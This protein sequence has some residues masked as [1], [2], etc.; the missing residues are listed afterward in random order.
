[1]K[2]GLPIV[3]VLLL[4]ACSVLFFPAQAYC[5]SSD[6]S[7]NK[8]I[9]YFIPKHTLVLK[10]TVKVK[11]TRS[12]N[13]TSE[14][15]EHYKIS[16][17][18]GTIDIQ[19]AGDTQKACK[20][21]MPASILKSKDLSVE[22]TP[23]GL[24]AS[25]N[26]S[27]KGHASSVL[28][29]L[30]KFTASVAGTFVGASIGTGPGLGAK[31]L[32]PNLKQLPKLKQL[33]PNLFL[34]LPD[35]K[36]NLN[37]DPDTRCTFKPNKL[38]G[39]A[40]NIYNEFDVTKQ[41]YISKICSAQRALKKIGK[42]M[43]RIDQLY[44]KIDTNLDDIPKST[45]STQVAEINNKSNELR[46]AIAGL[47]EQKQRLT[48]ALDAGLEVFKG[49]HGLGS[50]IIEQGFEYELELGEIPP[51]AVVGTN[52]KYP[53]FYPGMRQNDVERTLLLG[54]A[55]AYM[56]IWK[57]TGILVTISPYVPDVYINEG[58]MNEI[59]DAD[60]SIY[61]RQAKPFRITIYHAENLP[62]FGWNGGAKVSSPEFD[63]RLKLVST[64]TAWLMH[65]KSEPLA[66]GFKTSMWSTRGLSIVM[67][68]YGQLVTMKRT[69]TSSAA[70]AAEAFAS[71]TSDA[72]STYGSTLKSMQSIKDTKREI[73]LDAMKDEVEA[74]KQ[75]K[76][77]V[78]AQIALDGAS[79]S[80]KLLA[81]KTKIDAQLELKKQQI[82]LG[83]LEDNAN[84]AQIQLEQ[85]TL[86]AQQA[87]ATAQ[88]TGDMSLVTTTLKA[89]LEQLQAE[90][91]LNDY[92]A[93]GSGQTQINQLS[94]QIKLL[95]QQ[96]KQLELQQKINELKQ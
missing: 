79:A 77:A 68:K 80:S 57:E 39:S 87:L 40:K 16:T 54:I 34:R 32:K 50:T 72:I 65:P 88:A 26:S 70:E 36:L 90:T 14:I 13:A 6:T 25:I 49:E 7:P 92:Q 45:N 21:D 47:V 73:K 78:D 19:L 86:Q 35:K 66:L 17:T 31:A 5:A 94:M 55:P 12:V 29:N 1:M 59:K 44:E 20:L 4:V 64:K 61:Y 60:F 62:E 82:A 84:L 15:S 69:S 83:G 41:Y 30:A 43:D 58:E 71:A 38:T 11:K 74:L 51:D 9:V 2:R 93:A 3:F 24:L 27:S 95:E 89:Q 42:L 56:K 28:K 96:I 52:A 81:E 91:A 8:G 48:T 53:S 22:I 85:Q 46:K 67:N 76:A 75:K 63:T 23:E 33:G 10:G 18:D 37:I